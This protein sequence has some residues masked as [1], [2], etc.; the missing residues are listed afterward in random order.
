MDS[1]LQNVPEAGLEAGEAP[2]AEAPPAAPPPRSGFGLKEIEARIDEL[3][4]ECDRLREENL[5]L[6]QRQASLASECARLME[7]SEAVRTRV[8]TMIAR[9]K[10]LEDS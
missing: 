9:L 3:I 1:S 10:A 8:E 2:R 6:K 5:A 7:R 4:E